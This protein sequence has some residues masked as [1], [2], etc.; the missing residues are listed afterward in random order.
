MSNA[1]RTALRVLLD[2]EWAAARQD[3]RDAG[4]P[5]GRGRGLEIWIEYKQG[6]TV[7]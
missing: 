7:N 1:E 4:M 5:F 3:Y 2:L 6:T